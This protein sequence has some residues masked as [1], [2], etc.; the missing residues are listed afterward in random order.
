[1]NAA[2]IAASG[3]HHGTAASEPAVGSG[4]RGAG[5]MPGGHLGVRVQRR[6]RLGRRRAA[7]H[8]CGFTLRTE[9]GAARPARRSGARRAALEAAVAVDQHRRQPGRA[10]AADVG[11]DVVA[12]VQRLRRLAPPASA[13]ARA[14]ISGSGFGAPTS[15]EDSAPSSS[16]AQPGAVELLVQRDV[17]VGGRHELHA[18]R[19]Q[20]AQRRHRVGE[21]LEADRRQQRLGERAE[22]ERRAG[23]ARRA[24]PR[25]SRRR[26]AASPAASRPVHDARGRRRSRPSSRAPPPRATTSTPRRSRSSCAQARRGRQQLEQRAEGVDRDR[27]DSLR[28]HAGGHCRLP[29]AGVLGRQQRRRHGGALDR[30]RAGGRDAARSLL[31]APRRRGSRARSAAAARSAPCSTPACASCAG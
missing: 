19:P 29:V 2:T 22:V 4:T 3:A 27:T 21:G 18:R 7:R 28:R 31:R 26:S 9:R 16:G 25:R 12:D 30:A 24:A 10:R 8:R 6:R 17:P 11:L 15:A 5:M 23:R 1:M 13:S 20:R 14:K